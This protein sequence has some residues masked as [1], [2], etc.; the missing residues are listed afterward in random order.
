MVNYIFAQCN[1]VQLNSLCDRS[2]F[3]LSCAAGGGS[4][5]RYGDHR[6]R[7]DRRF[8]IF[9]ITMEQSSIPSLTADQ[10]SLN[11]VLVHC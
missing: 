4:L 2:W 11:T 3:V 6:H 7:S 9:H 1:A 5:P 10:D 8:H